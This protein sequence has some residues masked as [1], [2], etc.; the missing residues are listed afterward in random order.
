MERLG[1]KKMW[2]LDPPQ[3]SMACNDHT[4]RGRH[5]SPHGWV[6]GGIRSCHGEGW[7]MPWGK[8][9]A[10][11]PERARASQGGR[12]DNV[13]GARV[14]GYT[15]WRTRVPPWQHRYNGR[16]CRPVR[17]RRCLNPALTQVWRA[18]KSGKHLRHL[19]C[20]ML[21]I[22]S[23]VGTTMRAEIIPRLR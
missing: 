15:R 7:C 12:G 17:E 20:V 5:L 23:S 11:R 6:G 2:G 9:T 21:G 1:Y 16:T 22:L 8:E 13:A 14:A 19:G 18:S 4:A 10:W 3:S